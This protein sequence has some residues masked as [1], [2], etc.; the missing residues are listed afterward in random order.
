MPHMLSIQQ[1]M[2]NL[3]PRHCHTTISKKT[4]IHK[5]FITKTLVNFQ[6]IQERTTP[7]PFFKKEYEKY[8]L[9]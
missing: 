3:Q 6:I 7:K 8:W 4:K 5:I 9:T 2:N 1:H